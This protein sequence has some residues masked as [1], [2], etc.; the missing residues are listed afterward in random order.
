MKILG[1]CP[2][3]AI[4]PSRKKQT[5]REGEGLRIWNFHE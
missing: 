2:D 3:K 1:T 5:A 4:I